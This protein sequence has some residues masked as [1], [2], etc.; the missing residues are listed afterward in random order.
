MSETGIYAG[1][2]QRFRDY[3]ES[4]DNLLI[5]LKS[6]HTP[7]VE[8]VRPV[9]ELLEALDNQPEAP[10]S[11]QSVAVLLRANAALSPARLRTVVRELKS[12]RTSRTTIDS[13][14]A[15]AVV[16][17]EERAAMSRLRGS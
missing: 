9:L 11:V 7:A 5:E 3:A 12:W 4:V 16:L 17:E 8:T 13:L 10:A 14:E 15:F 1:S 2:Y 6:G